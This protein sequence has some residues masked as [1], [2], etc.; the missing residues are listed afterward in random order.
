MA[1]KGGFSWKRALGVTKQ[2]Q[3]LSRATGI[4]LTKSGRQR[5]IGK[6]L[7]GGGCL[8]WI[9]VLLAIVV[10]LGAFASAAL[11]FTDVPSGHPYGGAIEDLSSRGIINGFPGGT[12]GPNRAVTRQQLAKMIVLTM[13]SGTQLKLG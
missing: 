10:F 5:K 2:K 1:N 4:P 9:L 11:G 13:D 12:F 8:L 3:R 7:T 6:A